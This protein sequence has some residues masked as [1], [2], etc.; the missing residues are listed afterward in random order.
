[1]KL[2]VA[3]ISDR[4]SDP[5]PYVFSTPEAAIEYA[6]DQARELSR[7]GHVKEAELT[8]TMVREGWLFHA[9]YSGEGDDVWVVTRT[10]DDPEARP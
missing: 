5:E 10:L 7:H 4:H 3:M 2:Y 1:V 8:N 6:R 9:W